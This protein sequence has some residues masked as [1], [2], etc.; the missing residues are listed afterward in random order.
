[1]GD[2]K[3]EKCGDENVKLLE[4][5][6][7]NGLGR[8]ITHIMCVNEKCQAHDKIVL[9]TGEPNICPKCKKE[10]FEIEGHENVKGMGAKKGSWITWGVCHNPEC[11]FYDQRIGT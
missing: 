9:I 11:K 7:F 5:E 8:G 3:C 2:F 1:M 6:F 10:G 4:T